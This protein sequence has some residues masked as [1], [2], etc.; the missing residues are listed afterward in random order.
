MLT[1]ATFQQVRGELQKEVNVSV[2]LDYPYDQYNGNLVPKLA[3][4][5]GSRHQCQLL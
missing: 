3:L 4:F 2:Y 5:V 1:K